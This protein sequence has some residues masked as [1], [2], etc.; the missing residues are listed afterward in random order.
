[1]SMRSKLLLGF[2]LVIAMLV[3]T[4]ATAAFAIVRFGDAQRS[5]VQHDF[6]AV[7]SL[8]EIRSAQNRQRAEI[9]DMSFK[10]TREEQEAGERDIRAAFTSVDNLLARAREAKQHDPAFLARLAE[11]KRAIEEY[12]V[13]QVRQFQMI[14]D[15]KAEESRQLSVTGQGAIYDRIRKIADELGDGTENSAQQAAAEAEALGQ[16]SLRAIV[17]LDIVAV[18]LAIALAMFLHRIIVGPLQAVS[19]AAR[20][21]AAGDL[22]VSLPASNRRDELGTL[23]T[24]FDGMAQGLRRMVGELREGVNVLAAAATEITAATT[25]VAAGSTEAA[26][27]VNQTMTTVEEVKQTAQVSAQKARY[28][29]ETAQKSSQISV[30]GRKTVDGS[31]DGM[32]RIQQ[33]VD[34]IGRS[35]VKLSEQGH[36][37]GEIIASVNDL[38]EQ[39]NLL[40]VNAAIEAAKAGD[41]GRGFAVVAQEIRSLAE[42]SKQATAQV[43]AILGDIQKATD[44]A[45]LATEQGNKAVEAGTQMSARL[46]ESIRQLGD[47]ISEASQAATQIAASAQQQLAGMDQVSLAMQNINQSSSQNVAST[48]QAEATAQNLHELGQKLRT[49]VERYAV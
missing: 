38:A 23:A 24:T 35:I 25:Q 17:A 45:V 36:A 42:Q 3:G 15:G 26:V 19:T 2:G 10:K 44:S 34:A 14:Y 30:D 11:L 37:I 33:Q 8:L 21:I 47:S 12:R 31:V 46:G 41:Q 18:L 9:F 28:V 13:G 6:V 49:L 7:T 27:A 32:K 5:V 39:S 29:S 43:R 20:R 16:R 22:A 4:A 40:A 48:R 1:M